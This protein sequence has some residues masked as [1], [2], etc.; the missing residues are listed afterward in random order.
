MREVYYGMDTAPFSPELNTDYFYQSSSHE[1][2]LSYLRYGIHM[3]EGVMVITGES[4]TGKSLLIDHIQPD[5]AAMNAKLSLINAADVSDDNVFRLIAM[6]FDVYCPQAALEADTA[7]LRDTIKSFFIGK[8]SSGSQLLLIIDQAELLSKS[9]L[10]GIRAITRSVQRKGKSLLQ[11]VLLGRPALL[12][13]LHQPDMAEFN[14]ETIAPCLLEP[15]TPLEMRDYIEHHLKKAHWRGEPVFTE[16]GLELI[17]HCTHGVP[18]L[19]NEFCDY[20]LFYALQNGKKVIYGAVVKSVLEVLKQERGGIWSTVKLSAVKPL[21]L[22]P[23]PNRRGASSGDVVSDG[24][25]A[26]LSAWVSTDHSVKAANDS[27]KEAAGEGRT[28][29]SIEAASQAALEIAKETTEARIE[30]RERELVEQAKRSRMAAQLAP[31]VTEIKP[32]DYFSRQDQSDAP[33]LFDSVSEV[34]GL[35]RPLVVGAVVISLVVASI[36][37]VVFSIDIKTDSELVVDAVQTQPTDVDLSVPPSPLIAEPQRLGDKKEPI[38]PVEV[39]PVKALVVDTP[40]T[41]SDIHQETLSIPVEN[42]KD[43]AAKPEATVAVAKPISAPEVVMPKP[44]GPKPESTVISQ[45]VAPVKQPERVVVASVATKPAQPVAKSNVSNAVVT[46]I[47]KALDMFTAAYNKGSIGSLL[48]VLSNTAEID[49][50]K[51]KYLVSQAYMNLFQSTVMRKLTYETLQWR[52]RDGVIYG[53][54]VYKNEI[55]QGGSSLIVSEGDVDIVLEL[56]GD[57]V[58]INKIDHIEKP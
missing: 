3:G 30:Q 12:D 52:E 35:G 27:Q 2:A 33:L 11:V 58:K 8:A 45:K 4:G 6:A 43:A 17:F 38:Q 13:L 28:L 40:A 42:P 55:Q 51:G 18:S 57:E 16:Q 49:N 20:L 32:L 48:R 24:V 47:N 44:A 34:V 39:E 54:G 29:G 41:K 9:L 7:E 19:V 31:R 26:R 22:A 1:Q 15:L 23:I 10:K 50:S 56:V 21:K 53:K 14:R 36:L 5:L 25:N 37:L 46:K